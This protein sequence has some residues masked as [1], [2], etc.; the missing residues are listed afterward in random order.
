MMWQAQQFIQAL[1]VGSEGEPIN[2]ATLDSLVEK[3]K[4]LSPAA[5]DIAAGVTGVAKGDGKRFVAAVQQ[6]TP[7][8]LLTLRQDF[9]R[10]NV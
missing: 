8:H 7:S 4:T 9:K 1:L 6:I 3:A 5:L 2:Q 10:M